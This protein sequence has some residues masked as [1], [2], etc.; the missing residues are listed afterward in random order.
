MTHRLSICPTPLDLQ[1]ST[2]I[3]FGLDFL[4]EP[5]LAQTLG[6]QESNLFLKPRQ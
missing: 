6:I 4:T 3:S 5:R 2:G 1:I